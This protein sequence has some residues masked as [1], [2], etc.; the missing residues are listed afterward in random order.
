[1]T[2]ENQQ[3]R[4][5]GYREDL[6][7]EEKGKKDRGIVRNEGKRRRKECPFGKTDGFW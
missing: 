2:L 4:L 7:C 3:A 6:I 5:C 1:M